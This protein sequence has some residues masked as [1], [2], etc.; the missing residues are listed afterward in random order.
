MT[1][2]PC[3][4][5]A[6]IFDMPLGWCTENGNYVEMVGGADRKSLEMKCCGCNAIEKDRKETC[7]EIMIDDAAVGLIKS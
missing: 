1:Q 7:S 3:L 4:A 6:G 2:F 5:I